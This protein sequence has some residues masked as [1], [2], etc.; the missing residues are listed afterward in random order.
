MRFRFRYLAVLLLV[1]VACQAIAEKMHA[2]EQS[3][4]DLVNRATALSIESFA[5]SHGRFPA[6]VAELLTFD[7]YIQRPYFVWP[8]G[9]LPIDAGTMRDFRPYQTSVNWLPNRFHGFGGMSDSTI[10]G[11]V[12]TTWGHDGGKNGVRSEHVIRLVTLADPLE[13]EYG[14]GLRVISRK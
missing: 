7:R 1:W 9:Q 3:R 11:A 2:N 12:I 8:N 13:L 6:N 14:D 5:E 10:V 4:L